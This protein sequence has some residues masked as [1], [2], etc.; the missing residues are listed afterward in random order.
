MLTRDRE[1]KDD[2]RNVPYIWWQNNCIINSNKVKVEIVKGLK[3][4]L[5]RPL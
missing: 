2:A 3:Y 1:V 4:V 5:S